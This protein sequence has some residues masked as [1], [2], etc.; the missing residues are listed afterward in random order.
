MSPTITMPGSSGAVAFSGARMA[1]P[2][3]MDPKDT[4]E[5]HHRADIEGRH[6]S[7]AKN[8]LTRICQ[9][10]WALGLSAPFALIASSTIAMSAFEVSDHFVIPETMYLL[11]LCGHS[12]HVV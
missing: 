5:L 4:T 1:V 9:G 6:T 2:I 3:T 10:F 8:Q 7:V 11:A 12:N